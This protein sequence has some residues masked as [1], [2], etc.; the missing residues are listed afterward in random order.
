MM[1]REL[2]HHSP[3]AFRK[4]AMGFLET[5]GFPVPTILP[6]RERNHGLSCQWLPSM[7]FRQD[8]SPSS[9]P[10]RRGRMTNLRA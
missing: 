9:G 1:L 6:G 2:L 7:V 5:M 3:T 8:R 10:C 4:R